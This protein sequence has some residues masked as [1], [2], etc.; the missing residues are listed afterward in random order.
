M[1]V[2]LGF[3]SAGEVDS[4]IRQFPKVF[5]LIKFDGLQRLTGLVPNDF[6]LFMVK[7]HVDNA[8]DKKDV[9]S[10]EVGLIN[11]DENMVLLYIMDDGN[12]TIKKED[13]KRILDFQNAP[14]SKRGIK[15][16]SRGVLGNALQCCIGMAHAF[17]GEDRRPKY[18]ILICGEKRWAVGLRPSTVEKKIEADVKEIAK[19]AGDGD[20]AG[21]WD[22]IQKVPTSRVT[23][24]KESITSS[25]TYNTC[26]IYELPKI[27]EVCGDEIVSKI[28]WMLDVLSVLNSGVNITFREN[29]RSTIFGTH[30]GREKRKWVDYGFG[31]VWWYSYEEFRDLALSLGHMTVENFVTSF[32]KFRSRQSANKVLKGA[33]ITSYTRLQDI[34]DSSLQ[35]LFEVMRRNCKPIPPKSL[36]I[37]GENAFTYNDDD[38]A[39]NYRVKRGVIKC[40]R[41][42]KVE[43]V[44][45][46]VIEAAAFPKESFKPWRIVECVNFT[47]SLHRPFTQ[48]A[49]EKDGEIHALYDFISSKDCVVLLHY[50]CPNIK[51]LDLSK[52]EIDE[53]REV[54]EDLVS[55]VKNVSKPVG[56]RIKEFEVLEDVKKIMDSMPGMKF[57]LRQ[58]FYQLVAKHGYP[59]DKSFYKKLS[60]IL[61]Q[62][63]KTCI[64]DAERI[65]D[66]TRPECHNN[67]KFKSLEEYLKEGIAMMINSFDLNR[68]DNQPLYVEVWIEKEALS[69]II[70]GTCMKYRV[71]LIVGRGYSSY[72][73]ILRAVERFP[74]DKSIVILYMGDHDPPGLHIEEKLE[75]EIKEEMKRHGKQVFVRVK[76]IALT[77]DQIINYELP[78]S[79]L[80]KASQKSKE[81]REKFGD[82][83][84]ELDALEPQVLIDI[85]NDALKNHIDQCCWKEKQQEVA[86]LTMKLKEIF[87]KTF[88]EY[89]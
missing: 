53:P 23:I 70:L 17:W 12:P 25:I 5:D 88:P 77:M 30:V 28:H 80:K 27:E 66:I 65:V 3:D 11:L 51:W 19:D 78:A 68:W 79:P 55:I 31:D 52:G 56:E 60:K 47:V 84:W 45:P 32:K 61:K 42:G 20:L 4:N 75:S 48:W 34:D 59:N 37:A 33:N 41:G 43:K 13:L 67:P 15:G 64:I 2:K 21:E 50:V 18:P 54:A 57:T 14:S 29:K 39:G 62:A 35:R 86:A 8:L 71:N 9:S 7:E 40:E 16:I 44:I 46:Y 83:V 85:L 36:P 26:F 72:T 73:Q 89:T 38:D 1:G 22:I 58:I 24:E 76:R 74:N 49:Y 63:R 6:I 10:I 81:Y 82:K 87:A 69:R